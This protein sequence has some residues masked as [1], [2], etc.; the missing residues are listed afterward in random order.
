MRTSLVACYTNYLTSTAT[1]NMEE[2]AADNAYIP[3]YPYA[4]IN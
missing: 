2:R 1:L 3:Q 4:A